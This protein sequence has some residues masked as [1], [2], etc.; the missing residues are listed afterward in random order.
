MV[1]NPRRLLGSNDLTWTRE[2]PSDS[3]DMAREV[4]M[5]R[6]RELG[7][8]HFRGTQIP[9]LPFTAVF[10][11]AESAQE[12]LH[13]I[14]VVEGTDMD[15]GNWF[16][17]TPDVN[18]LLEILTELDDYGSAEPIFIE[19][20]PDSAELKELTPRHR[21]AANSHRCVRFRFETTL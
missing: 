17:D 21:A 19:F 6:V 11:R 4:A 14:A 8:E 16:G 2:G 15:E 9:G 3:L 10:E 13:S 5:T 18:A 20:P 1:L 7:A 12:T